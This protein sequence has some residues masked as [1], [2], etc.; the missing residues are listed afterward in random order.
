MR[1]HATRVRRHRIS[2]APSTCRTRSR[3]HTSS[4][5]ASD[6]LLERPS[7]LNLPSL[8]GSALAFA[9]LF[10]H[11]K[12]CTSA[13]RSHNLFF[14]DMVADIMQRY[15]RRIARTKAFGKY[16]SGWP[17]RQTGIVWFVTIES[18]VCNSRWPDGISDFGTVQQHD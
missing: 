9:S 2:C 15:A 4:G 17:C 13:A 16:T 14:L 8:C 18:K 3:T 7:L 11:G 6:A 1:V 5:S 12:F 10:W